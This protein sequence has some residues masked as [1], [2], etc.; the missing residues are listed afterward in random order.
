MN[1]TRVR[2][3]PQIRL[4]PYG[5]AILA[6]WVALLLKWLLQR[7]VGSVGFAIFQGA[8][9]IAAWSGGM[10]AGLLATTL[11]SLLINYFFTEPRYTFAVTDPNDLIRL[12]IFLLVTV[13]ISS[14]NAD[15]FAARELAE[16]N[17]RSLRASEERYRRLIE[18]AYEGVWWLDEQGKTESVNPRMAQMLGYQVEEM[19][20]RPLVEFIDPSDCAQAEQNLNRR[21]QGI[22]EQFELR[23]RHKD[24]TAV[25]TIVCST[26]ILDESGQ[27]AG[28]FAMVTDISDRVAAQNALQEQEAIMRSIFDAV[29]VLMS[30]VDTDQRYRFTNQ[31]YEQWYKHPASDNYGKH[32]RE[33][34][35]ENAYQ[36]IRPYIEAALSGQQV[37]YE[38][39][40]ELLTVGTRYI[41][42]T[43]IPQFE[44]EQV[45]GFVALVSDITDRK[46]A[47]MALATRLRQHSAIAELGQRALA[48]KDLF[49]LMDTATALVSQCLDV[50][51]C[52][53]LERL[54]DGQ[55][56]L[57]RAGVGWKPGLVGCATVSADRDSQAGYTLLVNQPVIVD[58]LRCETRFSGPP[59]LHEH[60]VVSGLSVVIQGPDA[61]FGV[62][63][64]HTTRQ[65]RFSA[66]DTNFLQAIANVLATTIERQRQAEALRQ[67]EA[68]FRRL[69]DS[70]VVGVVTA[71]YQGEILEA[72]DALLKLVGYTPADVATKRLHWRNLTPPEYQSQDEQVWAEM[73]QTGLC[74]PFEKE[75]YHRRGDRVPVLVAGALLT[76]SQDTAICLLLDL[77]ERKQAE[78]ALQESE[79][80]FRHMTDSAPMMVWMS[81]TD[82]RCNYFNQSWLRFTGRTMAQEMGNGWAQGVHPDDYQRCLETYIN[83]FEARQPFE[84]EYRL[85]RWDGEYRW[86][87]DLGM[88]RFTPEGN[89]LGYIGSCIDVSDRRLAEEALRH[90][91]E[92]FRQAMINAPFPMIIH[93]EDG[94]ILQVNT[95]WT[96]LSGYTLAEIP[97]I[98]AWAHK[99]YGE[100]ATLQKHVK[101]LYDLDRRVDEGEFTI[102]T[103]DGCQRVWDFSSAPLGRLPDGRRAL[104]SMAMDVSDRVAAEAE[105]RHLNESLEQRVKERTAQLEAANQELESFSYSVSHDLRAPL[106][107]ISGF[108]ELLQKQVDPQALGATGERYLKIIAET[109]KR[110]GILIDELLAFS[111]LGRTPLRRHWVDMNLLVEQVLR[112]C[113]GELEE[114]NVQWQVKLL[115]EVHGD[116]ALLRL[117]WQNLIDNAIKYTQTRDRAHIAIG[118]VQNNQEVIFFVRDNGVGFDMQYAHK[119]FGVFQ[120]LHG[121]NEFEGTGIGL[122]NVQR[123]IHRHGGQVW[124]EGE[125][126]GGATFYFSLPK[127]SE[128]P[129]LPPQEVAWS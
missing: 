9:V 11:S 85:R 87:L 33:V 56:L 77:T 93:A 59:L 37:S 101:H 88:P 39:Q 128:P 54:G 111:R 31:A 79:A 114:R 121:E 27:Y 44:G 43:Y 1:V 104:I 105:I 66:D 108:V 10:K 40:L 124:A 36:M 125:V 109:S 69:A 41:N 113:A 12:G 35:G 90:S 19:L 45:V 72:N 76:E 81:G 127:P 70:N 103:K 49:G 83:A 52:K 80:R 117:V 68:K 22:T 91:E 92:R 99:A 60:G 55:Q 86:I 30:F 118:S 84:M 94:E 47:E 95:A 78:A 122:A 75:F 116:P 28:A 126:D 119:L 67:S 112:S 23:F 6:V 2:F 98:T 89:F 82:K 21:R 51:Y 58:D 16:T 7:F 71:N 20:G 100:R 65:R 64:A 74:T 102:T 4:H 97:T 123:I 26:P 50:E 3:K 96:R 63:G 17:W 14:L 24:D 13:L 110:A 8:V 62:L 38:H 15:R 106:R 53:V 34:I 73:R 57:L 61:P 42:A 29:P 129:Q 25:W 107:H 46:Q 48:S 120:R 18:T 32:I 115:P 5:I